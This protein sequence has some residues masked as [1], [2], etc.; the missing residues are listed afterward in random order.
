MVEKR[1][2]HFDVGE[3]KSGIIEFI[4]R[5]KGKIGEPFIRRSL[6]EKY[7]GIDQGTVNRHLH[8]LQKLGGLELIPPS[9]KTTRSNRWNITTLKQLENVRQHFPDIQLNRYEKSLDIVSQYH[10]HYINPALYVIFRVQLLLSTSFFDLCIKNDTET[11]CAKAFEIYRFGEGFEEYMLIQNY[12]DDIYVKLTN[13][14]FKN[15]TFLLSVWNKHIDNSLKTNI[16]SDP[17]EYLQTFSLSKEL[18]QKI[19]SNIKPKAENVKEEVIGRKL[20]QSLSLRI[21]HEIFRTSLQEIA[22]E[23]KLPRTAQK[24]AFDIRDDIS[25]K[26]VEEDPQGLYHKLAKINNHQQK[27]QYNSPFIIFEHCFENDILNDT[28]SDEEKEFI[29]RKKSS[30]QKDNEGIM[31][32]GEWYIRSKLDT[33]GDGNTMGEYTAYDNLYDEYLNRYMIPC[34]EAS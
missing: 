27:I 16:Q 25:N 26:M 5:H 19:L 9:K 8:D 29:K 22:D 18:F 3:V 21:S 23:K 7:D 20:V 24:L 11:F 14:I 2:Y 4:L 31:S 6:Q 33:A 15:T 32:Y 30:V 17:S 28:V 10:L 12:I 13:T 1:R 34:L